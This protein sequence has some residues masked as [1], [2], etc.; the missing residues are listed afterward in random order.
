VS[1]VLLCVA[2]AACLLGG[3]GAL[4]AAGTRAGDRLGETIVTD[5]AAELGTNLLSF[6]VHNPGERGVLLGASV[7][8]RSVRLRFESGSFVRVPRRTAR[9]GLLAG[10]HSHVGAIDA[11]ATQRIRVAFADDTPRRAELVVAVGETDRLR[12]IHRAVVLPPAKSSG[13]FGS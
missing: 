6:T 1:A 12:L 9:S 10:R 7:R 2:L 4:L 8:P 3:G 11:L 13:L 5:V